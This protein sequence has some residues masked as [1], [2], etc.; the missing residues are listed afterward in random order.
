[1]KKL[2]V[3]KHLIPKIWIYT[4][5]Y[6]FQK[7]WGGGGNIDLEKSNFEWDFLNV[8]LPKVKVGG[9]SRLPKVKVGGKSQEFFK[10]R[11]VIHFDCPSFPLHKTTATP[12]LLTYS[13]LVL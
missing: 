5:I 10:T 4:K 7:F 2:D 13:A 1:M 3:K 6:T 8:G 9:K 12:S 11:K